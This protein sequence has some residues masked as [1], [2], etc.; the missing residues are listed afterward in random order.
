MALCNR[1]STGVLERTGLK[2]ARMPIITKS[3]YAKAALLT[4]RLGLLR[5]SYLCARKAGFFEM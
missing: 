1:D 5:L 3:F 4:L 2:G